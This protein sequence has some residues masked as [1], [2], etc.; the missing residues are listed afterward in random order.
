MW[1]WQAIGQGILGQRGALMPWSPVMLALGIGGYFALRQE[2][3]VWALI[4]LAGCAVVAFLVAWKAGPL[5]GPGLLAAGLVA[6]G[7]A[8]A[9]AR[10]QAVAAPVLD[11]R[12]YGPIEGRVVG[13][14]RSASGALRLTLDRVRLHRVREVPARVRISLHGPPGRRC[15]A[16]ACE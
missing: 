12:Y 3:P 16:P 7:V 9:G 5:L 11:F 1:M 8:L 13:M 4:A 14:D 15:R 10:A 6:A 2:P